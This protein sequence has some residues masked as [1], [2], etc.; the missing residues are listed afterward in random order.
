MLLEVS[1]NFIVG[2]S[3]IVLSGDEDSVD[4]DWNHSTAFVEVLDGDLGFAIGPQPW[5]SAILANIGEA[6]PKLSCKDVAERHQLRGFI[7]GIA[8]HV[9][10]VTG[11]NLLRALGEMAVD[12]LSDVRALLLNVNQNLAVIS[13]KTNI[14]GNKSNVTAGVTHDLLIVHIGF[15]CDLTKDHDHVGLG[16]SLA[17]DFAVWVLFEAGVE[18]CIRYLIAELIWVSLVH[19][20]RGE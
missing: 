11:P 15:G 3:L 16:A 7:S 20:F 5:A 13:I 4:P 12:T 9:T 10:L 17:G 18:Y 19:G 2:N 8:K 14:V 6:G 1:C